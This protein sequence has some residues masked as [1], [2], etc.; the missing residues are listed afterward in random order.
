MKL[1]A[2]GKQLLA[3]R[4]AGQHPRDLYVVLDWNLARAFTRL[5]IDMNAD[6]KRLDLRLVAGLDCTL[7]YLSPDAARAAIVA[8]MLLACEPRILN[9]ICTDTATGAVLKWGITK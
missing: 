5:V 9:T 8:D 1:P 2:Y 6:L 4:L 3:Q 7:A